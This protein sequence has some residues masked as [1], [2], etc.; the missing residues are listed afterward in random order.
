[1]RWVVAAVVGVSLGALVLAL[2]V[3][4]VAAMGGVAAVIGAGVW[5]L[6][7]CRHRGPLGLL[8]PVMNPD[9]T[10]TPAQW[11]CDRCGESWDAGFSSAPRVVQR[12]DGYDPSKALDA[13]RRAEDLE[14][15]Q[16]R[17]ALRRAGLTGTKSR[18]RI[19]RNP[20]EVVPI[21][22]ARLAK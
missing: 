6:G 19:H 17:L 8:P 21:T 5:W 12:F 20:A 1:M 13:A 11:Y 4:R 2:P 15:H 18:P 3:A 22:H 9:G 14:R 16:R 10:R 7:Q